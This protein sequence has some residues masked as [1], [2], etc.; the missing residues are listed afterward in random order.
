MNKID[1]NIVQEKKRKQFTHCYS[2]KCFKGT[3]RNQ[4]HHSVNKE[5]LENSCTVPL[6]IYILTP[7]YVQ[8]YRFYSPSFFSMSSL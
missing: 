8:G 2:D 7:D 3:V 6:S 1:K 4:T 5:T